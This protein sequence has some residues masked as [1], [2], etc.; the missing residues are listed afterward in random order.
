M[1]TP[2]KI[3]IDLLASQSTS[4]ALAERM[5]IPMLAARAMCERHE[6]DGLL[7][8]SKIGDLLTVWR[9]TYDGRVAAET[10]KATIVGNKPGS[11]HVAR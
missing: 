5:R 10:L 7:E 4:D 8:Q 6:R 11:P 1:T 2:D 9:L 3:L